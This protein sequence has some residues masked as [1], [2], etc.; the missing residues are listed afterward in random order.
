MIIAKDIGPPK[1]ALNVTTIDW[2]L[3][4]AGFTVQLEG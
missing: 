3:L 2:N 1:R 4:V